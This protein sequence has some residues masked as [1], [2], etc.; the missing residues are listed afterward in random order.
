MKHSKYF[1]TSDGQEF[2]TENHAAN[3]ARSLKDRTVTPPSPEA[4]DVTGAENISNESPSQEDLNVLRAFDP[5]PK[6]AY[7]SGK[8]LLKA[9]GLKSASNKK[10]D[11]FAAIAEAQAK[12]PS[13]D[14]A[15]ENSEPAAGEP[16]T[17]EGAGNQIT[18]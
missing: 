1:T 18:E 9:L 13:L 15:P 11:V 4:M 17:G 2:Y 7:E 3:H 16:G 12:L 8:K 10:D 14:A 6:D 5:S